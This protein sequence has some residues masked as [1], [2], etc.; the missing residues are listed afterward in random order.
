MAARCWSAERSMRSCSSYGL[1][2]VPS[3]Q[4]TSR[5][6]ECVDEE[7]FAATGALAMTMMTT[8]IAT[9]C[10]TFMEPPAREKHCA[11]GD[12]FRWTHLWSGD[13]EPFPYPDGIAP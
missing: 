6:G 4:S 9:R 3:R 13:T 5:L 1:F 2:H 8:P 10:V 7:D 12:P 11:R